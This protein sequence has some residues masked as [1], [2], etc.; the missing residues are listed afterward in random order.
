MATYVTRKPSG[1]SIKR[2]GNT[3]TATWKISDKDYDA[4]Q[5]MQY[6]FYTTKWGKWTN[7][8]IWVTTTQ[9]SLVIPV[10]DY[11]PNTKKYLNMNCIV[12]INQI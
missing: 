4:G 5:T 9:K 6:R 12:V 8:P 7:I 1:L 3:L 10:S 11:F 2:N